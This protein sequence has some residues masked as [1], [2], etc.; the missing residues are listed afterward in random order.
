MTIP[1]RFLTGRV[2]I[3]RRESTDAYEGN[4]YEPPTVVPARWFDEVRVVRSHDA[5]EVV[6]TAHVSVAVTLAPGDRVTPVAPLTASSSMWTA[7]S[8]RFTADALLGPDFG[9]RA[10]EVVAVRRNENT[11]GHF[12]HFVGYLT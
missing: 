6:S 7:D 9:E 10:R 8:T 3:E 4:Q 2:S 5:R 12:S 11:R 1:A